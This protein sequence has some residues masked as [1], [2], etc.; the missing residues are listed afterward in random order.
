MSQPCVNT[1]D[2]CK[3]V[4]K[5]NQCSNIVYRALISWDSIPEVKMLD[6]K[7]I[8]C[9]YNFGPNLGKPTAHGQA[10]QFKETQCVLYA[11]FPCP[12]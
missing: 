5:T 1:K 7:K 6:M 8:A 2:I 11:L 10:E 9:T 12:Y 3:N 4:M